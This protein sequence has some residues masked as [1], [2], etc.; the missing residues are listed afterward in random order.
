MASNEDAPKAM[1]VL[2][3]PVE[4]LEEIFEYLSYDEIAKKRIVSV[5]CSETNE[6]GGD[7]LMLCPFVDLQEGGPGVPIA[8][9][10]GLPED[11]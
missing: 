4:I 8:A 5:G 9:E 3:L 6:A 7:C 10:S 11:D 2:D 1:N